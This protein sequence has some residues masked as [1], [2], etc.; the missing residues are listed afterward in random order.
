[1]KTTHLLA[2]SLGLISLTQADVPR[3][4][5]TPQEENL[6][7]QYTGI[8]AIELYTKPT[9]GNPEIW[10]KLPDKEG[11]Y[12]LS[13]NPQKL[14]IY[15][16]DPTGAFYARQT[17]I[18]LLSE[19]GGE[20]YLQ[21]Q[22][23]PFEGKKLKDIIGSG[24]L[25][26][27]TIIDWPD[28]PYRG[29]VE[30]YYGA[31]WSHEARKSQFEFYGRNKLN[32]YIWAPKDDPYHHGIKSYEPYPAEV[33]KQIKELCDVAK[34]NHVKFVWAVHPANTVNWN[35]DG[36]KYDLNRLV[37]KLEQMYDLGVRHFGVFIDD[38]NGEINKAERQVALCNYIQ[39]NFIDKKTDVGPII[40]CPTGYNKSWANQKYLKDLGAGLTKDQHVM[41]TGNTVCHDIT[42][43]GQKWVK[44]T[45]GRPTFIWWNW[46]V[47]DYCTAHLPM[48]RTYGLEQHEDM[49][50]LMTGFVS[51]PMALPEASKTAL[52]GVGDYSWNIMGFDSMGNWTEG[53]KRLY[54]ESHAAMQSFAN[55][56]SDLGNNFHGYRRE[57][58]VAINPVV[59]KLRASIKAGQLDKEALAT[60]KAEF[61][62]LREAAKTIEAAGDTKLVVPEIKPW[63]A[64][65]VELG[66][67]GEAAHDAITSPNMD[68]LAPVQDLWDKWNEGAPNRTQHAP[69][70]VGWRVL[71]PLI[72]EMIR[73]AEQVVYKQLSGG[74]PIQVPSPTFIASKGNPKADTEKL[75]DNT[76]ASFWEC[77]AAQQAGDWYGLDFG[78]PK[79]IKTIHLN[80]GGSRP[81]DFFANGQFEYSADGQT[82]QALG[83]PIGGAQIYVDLTQK[84]KEPLKTRYLRYRLT[85]GKDNWL[86][87]CT[88]DVNR[89]SAPHVKTDV[90][91]W[92][93]LS[94]ARQQN[95]FFGIAK[96]FE[97]KSMQ[98]GQSVSMVLPTPVSATWM[99]INLENGNLPQ[100]ADVTLT[101]E[102]GSSMKPRFSMSGTVMVAQGQQLPK[103][104]VSKMTLT[105]KSQSPQEVKMS[106]FKLD[107]PPLDPR[108][109]MESASDRDLMSYF[110]AS[111]GVNTSVEVPANAKH[112]LIV[113]KNMQIKG[114]T[115]VKP[116]VQ[117]LDITPGAKTLQLQ[118]PAQE[119]ARI[120][121]IIFTDK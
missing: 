43:E 102:D 85:Q 84:G 67:M 50:Q 30:G 35:K 55:H 114:A 97:V 74:R 66:D 29:S 78:S 40:M 65:A 105:N 59:E 64:L 82:W 72:M 106:M 7:D 48:G 110:D 20:T 39:K 1:M 60:I 77:G 100:W 57:E 26:L 36:G 4:F 87:I 19:K 71:R 27:G 99:E 42:L 117:K 83:D 86:A 45:L 34:K 53:M 80:T 109:S 120:F 112:A 90:A 47:H 5:P 75:F 2:L 79:E 96:N 98:P 68:T 16:H 17:V 41:W 25:P 24:M 81:Q 103:K 38:S 14:D 88:F 76:D 32:T 21:A 12:A 104:R 107:C 52:F 31:P 119:G 95:K 23:D 92:E 9:Q 49:K 121:E 116:N 56:S 93:G 62:K 113:C 13:I 73:E 6:R 118:S 70:V 54:P 69:R 10:K 94:V 28:M 18:Q 111:R 46:P 11:A 3:I 63:L 22:K 15:A 61:I 115:Q 91:G 101:L 44:E 37:V 58:S 89:A 8:T 33:A 108:D 51:N